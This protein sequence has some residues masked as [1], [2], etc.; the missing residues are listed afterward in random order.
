MT[1]QMSLERLA[2]LLAFARA[3]SMGSYTA[4]ARSLSVSPSAVSKSVQRLERH[5][6]LSLFT[7]T[8]RSLTQ[9]FVLGQSVSGRLMALPGGVLVKFKP[10]WTREQVDAWVASRGFA[11]ARAMDFGKNWFRI[12]TLPGVASLSAAN[13]IFESGEVLAA[14]PNWWMQTS[15]K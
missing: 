13:A 7:R 10:D 2:G 3:G 11:K 5:L 8:T 12:D 1:E 9:V 4:A 15:A 14:S 6:G